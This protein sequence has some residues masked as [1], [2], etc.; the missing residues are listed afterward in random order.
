[1]PTNVPVPVSVSADAADEDVGGLD[2]AVHEALAVGGVERSRDLTDHRDDARELHRA[3]R[4]EQ[5]AQVGAVDVPH[6]Q[7]QQGS[8]GPRVVDGDHVGVLEVGHDPRLA[9]EAG[10]ERLVGRQRRGQHL[11]GDVLALKRPEV[12]GQVHDAHAALAD[13]ALDAEAGESCSDLPRGRQAV[14]HRPPVLP[15]YA[16]KR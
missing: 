13:L 6:H 8:V 4:V 5:R 9:D 7:I 11:D 10:P 2:V 14:A 12:F 15:R 1:V 16:S 3:C